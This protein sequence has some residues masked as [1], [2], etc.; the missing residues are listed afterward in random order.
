MGGLYHNSPITPGLIELMKL[1]LGVDKYPLSM[2]EC[3]RRLTRYH[4]A[5][6][7]DY[8]LMDKFWQPDSD[9]EL[10][11]A[12]IDVMESDHPEMWEIYWGGCVEWT[13]QIGW[14]LMLIKIP[15]DRR[16]RKE[17]EEKEKEK[18]EK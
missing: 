3:C 7:Y 12:M 17:K 4:N 11:D 9:K 5:D 13:P 2:D 1:V 15:H 14:F 6:H 16:L 8:I 18:E 10:Y